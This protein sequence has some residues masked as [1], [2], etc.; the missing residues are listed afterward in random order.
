MTSSKHEPVTS[1]KAS[2]RGNHRGRA[3]FSD[4]LRAVRCR[5]TPNRRPHFSVELSSDGVRRARGLLRCGRDILPAATSPDGTALYVCSAPSRSS[6]SKSDGGDGCGVIS[7]DEERR[8]HGAR[9]THQRRSKWCALPEMRRPLDMDNSSTSAPTRP[10]PRAAEDCHPLIFNPKSYG[11]GSRPK[12]MN[13]RRRARV[14]VSGWAS[15]KAPTLL[16]YAVLGWPA[17]MQGAAA[18]LRGSRRSMAEYR[19]NTN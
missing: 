10:Q 12:G 11:C 18:A 6:R 2:S 13:P 9:N 15:T 8:R 17:I 7:Q 4:L 5:F 19:I 1:T 16:A 3:L 14:A